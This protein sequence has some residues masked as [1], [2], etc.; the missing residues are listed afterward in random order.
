M[1]SEYKAHRQSESRAYAW[2]LGAG[3]TLA[4]LALV[5][6]LRPWDDSYAHYAVSV[7]ALHSFDWRSLLF[8]TWN[9]PL[10]GLLFGITG[11]A[12]IS[13]ARLASVIVTIVTGLFLIKVLRRTLPGL[14]ALHPAVWVG[15]LVCQQAVLPQSYLTMTELLAAFLMVAGL[16]LWLSE[17]RLAGMLMVGLIPYAR[18]EGMFVAAWCVL[19]FVVHACVL[20]RRSGRAMGHVFP[21][22]FAGAAPFALWWAAGVCLSGELA[23]FK[24]GYAFLRPLTPLRDILLVN[25]LTALPSV[26]TPPQILLLVLGCFGLYVGRRKLFGHASAGL[27]VGL[28]LGALVLHLGFMSAIVVYPKGTVYESIGVSAI[29]ARNFNMIAPSLALLM[30][31][32]VTFLVRRGDEGRPWRSIISILGAAA[33]VSAL[34]ILAHAGFNQRKL[35]DGFRV[36]VGLQLRQ[37][38]MIGVASLGILC[39]VLH[40]A[41]RLGTTERVTYV[42]R[43]ACVICIVAVPLTIPTFWYPLKGHDH[44]SATQHEFGQWFD[45]YADAGTCPLVIQDMNGQ[46]GFFTKHDR[47]A[48]PWAYP[49]LMAKEALAAPQG[50]LVLIETDASGAPRSR[51]P[52][53]LLRSLQDDGAFTLMSKSQ[54]VSD[55]SLLQRWCNLIVPYNRPGGFLV[56]GKQGKQTP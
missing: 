3:L 14:D 38:T 1:T 27:V 42:S 36:L 41:V 12:C 53:T 32:G 54:A 20:A 16:H 50:A 26:I 28:L 7:Q 52:A 49:E 13:C 17:R 33:L 8:D 4:V 10:P 6:S 2:T 46:L 30:C 5:T 11:L 51:Y 40:R 55:V 47:P 44:A 9:K 45:R 22:A 29:N 24:A 35:G 23:W 39:I 18:I 19:C 25:A 31:L 34:L 15:F 56:Y 43:W 21:L 48:M 37:L